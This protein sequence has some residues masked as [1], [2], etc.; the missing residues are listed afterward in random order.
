MV[1]MKPLCCAFGFVG[2]LALAP[3]PAEATIIEF[4]ATDLSDFVVG[5]DLWLY[6]YFVSEFVFD[7]DQGFSISFDTALY[8]NLQD[9]PPS[10]GT[11]WDLLAIQPSLELPSPGLYDALALVKSASLTQPFSL[12]FT[13][14]GAPG[15]APGSQTFTV[16]EFD[17]KGN[18]SILDVGKTSPVPEPS[19]LILVGSGLALALRRRR[20]AN[21]SDAVL[22]IV[23]RVGLSR[24]SHSRQKDSP[25]D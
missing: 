22:R 18:I 4:E 24:D 8:R 11:D 19:T 16:N 25:V 21:L 14:L 6:H 23:T 12:S 5:E 1:K 17:D 7:V 15:S 20:W 9:P 2:A 10:V 13:W 3:A